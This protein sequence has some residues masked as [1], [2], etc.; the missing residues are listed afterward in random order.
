MSVVVFRIDDFSLSVRLISVMMRL[1]RFG[2]VKW[3]AS[4]AVYVSLVK[5][6]ALL[7]GYGIQPFIGAC[8]VRDECLVLGKLSNFRRRL[9]YE[10]T[11]LNRWGFR[12]RCNTS[13][14]KAGYDDD[15]LNIALP[16]LGHPSYRDAFQGLIASR[17]AVRIRSQCAKRTTYRAKYRVGGEYFTGIAPIRIHKLK[18]IVIGIGIAIE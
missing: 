18:G 11:T 1:R 17:H 6:E 5:P 2:V 3:L 10:L 8:G 4:C 16:M 13:S 9:A 15:C 7:A 12:A 14:T